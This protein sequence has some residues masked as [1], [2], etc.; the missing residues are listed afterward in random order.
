MTAPK[1]VALLDVDGTLI[2]SNDAHAL[3]WVDAFAEHGHEVSFA[4]VRALIGKG[5][6]KLMPE[7]I[8][9]AKDSPEGEAIAKQRSAIFA[10]AYLP[11]LRAFPEARELLLALKDAGLKLVIATS[12]QADELTSLLQQA[13]LDD[14]IQAAA[15]S[16]DAKDSKPD[17]DIVLA[18][19]RAAGCRPAEAVMLGDTPY[20]VEASVKAGVAVVGLRCGGWKDE[21]LA[22]AAAIYDDVRDLRKHL[23]GSPFL[24]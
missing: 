19:L 16:S 7:T 13:G 1:K 4:K 2:D 23:A 14:L 21:D 24:T 9:V 10:K 3:A 6:D 15:T 17:P 18:A 11:Q 20:D 12:A 22:G 5:G 8:H